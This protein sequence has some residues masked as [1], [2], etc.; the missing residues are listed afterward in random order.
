MN[1]LNWGLYSK[2]FS[3]RYRAVM[4]SFPVRVFTRAAF[5]TMPLSGSDTFTAL[6]PASFAELEVMLERALFQLSGPVAVRYP[7]G[8]E[9]KYVGTGGEGPAA[10][11]RW[12][13]GITLSGYGREIND[14]L[15]AADYLEEEEALWRRS[16]SVAEN[17][18]RLPS[19]ISGGFC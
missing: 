6:A 2:L 8:G 7:R 15:E 4:V 5:N 14:I 1:S 11:L 16:M 10:I 3:W 13:D 9:G 17:L 12:G 18:H 19:R